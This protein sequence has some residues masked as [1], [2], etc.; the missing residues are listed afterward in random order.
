MKALKI[1]GAVF[2]GLMTLAG[3]GTLLSPESSKESVVANLIL[4]LVFLG[5][6]IL[7]IFRIVK[8]GNKKDISKQ[9]IA[10]QQYLQKQQETAKGE[11]RMFTKKE[12]CAICGAKLH[13][14]V[15][16]QLTDGKICFMCARICNG[17]GFVSTS[18][19]KQA[20]EE[21]RRR[22]RLFHES[23]VVSSIL[24]GFIFVDFEHQWAYA[25]S[26]KNPK[27]EILMKNRP[28][29]LAI[30]RGGDHWRESI[31]Q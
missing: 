26:T 3:I 7:L 24:C 8:N 4:T 14:T 20:L 19:V 13:G 22:Y 25:S 1:I 17:S 16:T 12:S 18:T 5:L 28:L 23:I 2:C 31:A 6:T 9:T 10:N 29:V 27:V 30:P 21:N 11:I 15:F